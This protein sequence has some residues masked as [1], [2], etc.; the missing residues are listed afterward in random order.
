[1]PVCGQENPLPKGKQK[2]TTEEKVIN[3]HAY[4]LVPVW[5]ALGMHM[6]IGTT[7]LW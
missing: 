3:V 1:M 2:T 6:H 5:V 7:I 4:L